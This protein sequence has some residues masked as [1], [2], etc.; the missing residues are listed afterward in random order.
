ME[1]TVE[2]DVVHKI[3]NQRKHRRNLCPVLSSGRVVI[4]LKTK[5]FLPVN[6]ANTIATDHIPIFLLVTRELKVKIVF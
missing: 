2:G 5:L 6:T 3:F 1:D 4:F